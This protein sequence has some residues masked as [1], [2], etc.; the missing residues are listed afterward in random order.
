MPKNHYT[1]VSIIVLNRKRKL[2]LYQFM[3]MHFSFLYF[4]FYLFRFD[5]MKFCPIC[6]CKMIVIRYIIYF[7]LTFPM[8][9]TYNFA[10]FYDYFLYSISN[11]FA[12]KVDGQFGL[13]FNFLFSILRV[14]FKNAKNA[15]DLS[16]FQNYLS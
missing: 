15:F 3:L 8:G 12:V 10:F 2:L 11:H 7:R 16:C 13:F 6:A 14:F 4:Y 9:I 5:N 1:D